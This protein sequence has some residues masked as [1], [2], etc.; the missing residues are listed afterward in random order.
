VKDQD[1][2]IDLLSSNKTIVDTIVGGGITVSERGLI[3]NVNS[4]AEDIIGYSVAELR[5]KI[6]LSL[7]PTQRQGVDSYFTSK[8]YETMHIS[9]APRGDAQRASN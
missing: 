4:A 9:I 6:S 8:A 5:G 3:E 7:C 1:A 2:A